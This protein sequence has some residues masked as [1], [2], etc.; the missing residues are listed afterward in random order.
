MD[1]KMDDNIHTNPE[2]QDGQKAADRRQGKEAEHLYNVDTYLYIYICMY[3][4]MY[5]C[6]YIYI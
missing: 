6:M 4:C 3:V 2:Y 1:G 5:V